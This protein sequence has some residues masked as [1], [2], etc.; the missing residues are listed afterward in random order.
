MTLRNDNR[1]YL[2]LTTSGEL[3]GARIDFLDYGLE[4]DVSYFYKHSGGFLPWKGSDVCH[5]LFCDE[6]KDGPSCYIL[7][8]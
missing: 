7:E 5:A 4:C 3:C 2:D 6:S 1:S 8:C